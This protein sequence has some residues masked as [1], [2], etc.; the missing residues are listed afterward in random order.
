MSN[1]RD[2]RVLGRRG[3]RELSHQETESVQGGFRTLGPCT[4]PRPGFPNGDSLPGDCGG[5]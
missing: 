3:A 5:V 1:E 4:G 2:N